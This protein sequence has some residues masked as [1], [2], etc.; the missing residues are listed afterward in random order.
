MGR[1]LKRC[2]TDH[3]PVTEPLA[4][5]VFLLREQHFVATTRRDSWWVEWEFYV[6]PLPRNDA[7]S[8]YELR[9]ILLGAGGGPEKERECE[10]LPEKLVEFLRL[11]SPKGASSAWAAYVDRISSSMFNKA[12]INRK[13]LPVT[14]AFGLSRESKQLSPVQGG[15]WRPV[16]ERRSDLFV[17]QQYSILRRG[18]CS[19]V[20][21]S[22]WVEALDGVFSFPHPIALL[23]LEFTGITGIPLRASTIDGNT[24]CIEGISCRIFSLQD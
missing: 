13:L 6:I 24:A 16:I 4:G 23:I 15:R 18:L 14:N 20:R 3:K 22:R 10:K 17:G 1:D 19:P 5:E 7:D 21:I 2:K 9:P 8:H 11:S 12:E